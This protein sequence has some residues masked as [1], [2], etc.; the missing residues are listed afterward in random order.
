MAQSN[1]DE[2]EIAVKYWFVCSFVSASPIACENLDAESCVTCVHFHG[3]VWVASEDI[4][5]TPVC[6][7]IWW[8]L[9]CSFVRICFPPWS[10]HVITFL[11]GCW[12]VVKV[13]LVGSSSPRILWWLVSEA[14]FPTPREWAQ[15]L[16]FLQLDKRN[17]CFCLGRRRWYKF[18]ILS[19]I[20]HVITAHAFLQANLLEACGVPSLWFP[21]L[22]PRIRGALTARL[23][24]RLSWECSHVLMEWCMWLI[25]PPSPFSP[26][27]HLFFPNSSPESLSLPVFLYSKDCWERQRAGGEGANRGWDGCMSSSTQRTW[28]WPSSRRWWRAG[29]PGRLQS[30]GSQRGGHDWVAEQQE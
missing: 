6:V 23:L 24:S 18:S 27:F 5:S 20:L 8:V 2:E 12:L 21:G 17:I 3:R 16:V 9:I 4:K 14:E 1:Y 15:R 13:R 10:V 30:M 7:F 22:L 29:K 25:C 26:L 11:W 28:V 19:K